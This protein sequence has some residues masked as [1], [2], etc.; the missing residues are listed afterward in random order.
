MLVIGIHNRDD[1]RRGGTHPLDCGRGQPAPP[2]PLA[3]RAEALQMVHRDRLA[4]VDL[5]ASRCGVRVDRPEAEVERI[6]GG[7]EGISRLAVP[8][9]EI[10]RRIADGLPTAF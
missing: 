9:G 4:Y 1:R 2:D 10:G 8:I 3:I 6:W 5:L 7:F